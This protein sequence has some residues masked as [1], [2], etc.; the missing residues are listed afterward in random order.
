MKKDRNCTNYARPYIPG[1]WTNV[2]DDQRKDKTVDGIWDIQIPEGLFTK[3]DKHTSARLVDKLFELTNEDD[4]RQW[5][6]TVYV[7]GILGGKSKIRHVFSEHSRRGIF[8]TP[9]LGRHG[10]GRDRYWQIISNL[11]SDE[12]PK[13]GDDK[14]GHPNC[15]ITPPID[16][17]NRHKKEHFNL[18]MAVV[19]DEIILWGHICMNPNR[20]KS[21]QKSQKHWLGIKI[22]ICYG[23]KYYNND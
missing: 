8:P 21:W 12:K 7:Q 11:G 13:R 20:K 18:G 6:G 4:I 15:K 1:C 2:H 10:I 14:Y 19:L 22:F 9:N 17:F 3:R 23:H 5:I 16:S